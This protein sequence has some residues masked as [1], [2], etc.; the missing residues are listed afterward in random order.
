MNPAEPRLIRVSERTALIWI[1]IAAV[2]MMTSNLRA[3]SDP[4]FVR[5]EP[6]NTPAGYLARLLI[7]EVPFPGE[8]AYIS[9][10]ESQGSMLQILWVLHGRLR[11]IPPGY[12]QEHL[13]G[14]RADD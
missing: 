8:R 3:Q 7:N 10:T 12:R 11:L 9:E 4:I 14:V 13:A 5:M 1:I 6:V 2:A